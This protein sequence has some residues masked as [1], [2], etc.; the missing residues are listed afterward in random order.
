M[1]TKPLDGHNIIKD[2]IEQNN[3]G[4]LYCV[5]IYKFTY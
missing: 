4:D 2:T 3:M 5:Q 1:Y